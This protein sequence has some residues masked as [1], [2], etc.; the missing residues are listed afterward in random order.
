MKLK[1]IMKSTSQEEIKVS[2]DVLNKDVSGTKMQM[3]TATSKTLN[4]TLKIN[5]H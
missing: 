3:I 2:T 4:H 1:A 5:L